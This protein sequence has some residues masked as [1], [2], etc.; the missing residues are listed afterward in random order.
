MGQ[1]NA[2]VHCTLADLALAQQRGDLEGVRKTQR[3]LAEV[4]LHKGDPISAQTRL[5]PL[6]DRQGLVEL[7]VN[8]VLPLL[9]WAHLDL[10]EVEAAEA[11]ATQ[12]VT[13]LREHHDHFDLVDA[14][15]MQAAVWIRQERWDEAETDLDEALTLARAMPYPYAEAKALATYGDL[16]IA[17]GQPARASDHYT[18]A[19]SILRPL[20]EVP[21]AERIQRALG[22]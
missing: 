4:D 1:W 12:T 10:G 19:L 18:A 5:L 22:N 16:M 3:M 20:G 13:R 15:R 11:L 7:D 21:Y 6:L 17:R 8:P 2:A 14:L 9:V